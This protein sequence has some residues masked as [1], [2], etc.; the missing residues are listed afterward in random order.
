MKFNSGYGSVATAYGCRAW[1]NFN[2]T[3]TIAIRDSGNVSSITDH[4]SGDYTVTFAVAMPDVNY[5]VMGGTSEGG[6]SDRWQ[7]FYPPAVG[8][9]RTV[10]KNSAAGA[11]DSVNIMGGVFR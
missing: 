10:N 2:G 9:I 1:W 7:T 11:Y 5:A 6:S 4:S 8:S 3:G